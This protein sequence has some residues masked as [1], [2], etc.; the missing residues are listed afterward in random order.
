MVNRLSVALSWL[1]VEVFNNEQLLMK[2][3]C[4]EFSVCVVDE[5]TGS[6]H[7]QLMSWGPFSLPTFLL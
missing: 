4:S 3:N 6:F 1:D 5:G 7:L 2:G